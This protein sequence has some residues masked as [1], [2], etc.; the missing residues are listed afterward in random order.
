ME[1][2]IISLIFLILPALLPLAGNAEESSSFREK[3]YEAYQI[4][5]NG[6]FEAR[7]GLR[8]DRSGPEEQIH[9]GDALSAGPHK[10]LGLESF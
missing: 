8:T 10:G 6:F 7:G 2:K 3:L 5:V 4:E 9:R 1:R